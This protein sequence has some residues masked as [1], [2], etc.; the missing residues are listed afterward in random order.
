ML[1]PFKTAP[2]PRP[3]LMGPYTTGEVGE[4][5]RARYGPRYKSTGVQTT[6]RCPW[7]P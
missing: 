4:A 3:D 1:K 2:A 5:F 7:F 6:S